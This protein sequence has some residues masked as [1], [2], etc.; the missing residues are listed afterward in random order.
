MS[1]GTLAELP[2]ENIPDSISTAL[3]DESSVML[4]LPHNKYLFGVSGELGTGSEKWLLGKLGE[5]ST[6]PQDVYLYDNEGLSLLNDGAQPT[7][8]PAQTVNALRR[9]LFMH[10]DP[11]GRH[12]ATV[13]MLRT[14]MRE[15]AVF[16]S[17]NAAFLDEKIFAD[18]M[19]NDSVLEKMYW[20]LR[21][22][23]ARGELEAV[24]RLKL[25]LKAGPEV[26]A[27][28]GHDSRVWLSIQDIPDMNA[29]TELEELSFS[30]PELKRL[31]AQ[32]VSPMV[33]YNPLSGWLILGR[34]GRG[35]DIMFSC[36]AYANHDL[37]HEL[38]D[39]R[40]LTVQDIIHAI[41]GEYDTIQAINERS[42]YR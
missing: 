23:L 16:S 32:N 40:N 21:F 2:P 30:V 11:P 33:M 36:W 29:V 34:F 39:N 31:S 3:Y 13:L 14:I 7:I 5:Y 10:S 6:Q 17:E 4:L 26:F 27:Q 41:W 20:A 22:A 35:R 42:K 15:H 12:T 8:L 25:W 9:K 24:K 37:W 18:F 19:K 28:P 1:N 38:R